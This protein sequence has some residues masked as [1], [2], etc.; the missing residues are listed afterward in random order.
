MPIALII[1]PLTYMRRATTINDTVVNVVP[2]AAMT[3]AL[4]SASG[5][6]VLYVHPIFA[7]LPVSWV[8]QPTVQ[9]KR[10]DLREKCGTVGRWTALFNLAKIPNLTYQQEVP[11][12][13]SHFMPSR[14]RGDRFELEMASSG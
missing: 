2:T 9:R 7:T 14:C 11:V 8:G 12:T 10:Y 3:G 6:L 5:F 13:I 1:H 4:V